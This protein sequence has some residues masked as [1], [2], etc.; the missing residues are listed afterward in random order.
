MKKT[1]V[2][3]LAAVLAGATVLESCKK[4]EDGPSLSF[5][6]RKE[7]VA[8][9][10]KI[11]K[12]L[13]GGVEQSNP[14]TGTITFDKDG[15]V[16]ATYTSFGITITVSGTWQLVNND[17]DLEVKTTYNGV[18]T[19]STVNILKLKEKELWV[20]DPGND[21]NSSGDDVETHYIPA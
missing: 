8:N 20:K 13:Q 15:N 1:T 2:I 10:W 3:M 6:S 17:E 21:A 12:Q 11:E 16:S 4:Y 19:T 9:T 18:S 14:S 7:R 5:R